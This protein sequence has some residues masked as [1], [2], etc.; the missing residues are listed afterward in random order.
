MPRGTQLTDYEK[1]QIDALRKNKL[2]YREIAKKIHRSTAVVGNYLQDPLKYGTRKRSGRKPLLSPREKRHIIKTASNKQVSSSQI[3]DQLCL[4]VSRWTVNRTLR[5]SG[6]LQYQ[7]KKSSPA[8]TKEHKAKRLEWARQHMTWKSEWNK[9]VWSDEKKFN[10]DGPDGNN[11]Y[12]HDIRKEKLFSTRRGMGGGSVMVWASFCANGTS[13]ICFIKGRINAIGYQDI[14]KN[15]LEDIG[16]KVGAKDWLFQQDNAPIHRAKVNQGWFKSKKIEVIDWPALSPDL[17][18]IENLW[19]ILVRR[20]YAE[21]RVFQSA[22]E[23]KKVIEDEWSKITQEELKALVDSM[24]N[25]IF[26]VI[27]LQGGKIDY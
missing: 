16:A 18:P 24:P 6:N 1:G 8:L 23:L 13:D 19:G 11:Y 20:V 4:K 14:L 5:D 17:N 27:R 10:L 7:K 12:W 21:G 25:R 2:S 9:V 26:E 3:V 22:E 15:H